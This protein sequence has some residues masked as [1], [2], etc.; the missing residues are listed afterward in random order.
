MKTKIV[1]VGSL[2][3]NLALAAVLVAISLPRAPFYVVAEA[4]EKNQQWDLA[5]SAWFAAM[6]NIEDLSARGELGRRAYYRF[7]IGM[8]YE[9]ED[10]VPLAIAH[11]QDALLTPASEINVCMGANGTQEMQKDLDDLLTRA[12]PRGQTPQV[13]GATSNGLRMAISPVMSGAM[14]SQEAEFYVAFQNVGDKDVVLNLG[15]M[16]ANGKVHFPDSVRLLLTDAQGKTREL[17]FSDKR[18]PGIAGRVDDYTVA[19]RNGAIY[20]LRL[21]L[22]QYWSPSTDEFESRLDPGHYRIAAQFGGTGAKIVNG[23]MEG[24]ELVNFWK[25]L[26]ESNRLEFDVSD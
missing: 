8:T 14:P 13:W 1:L 21:N 10:R 25:G 24:V 26:L 12:S 3:L 9:R 6:H 18:Y 16:L 17:W 7:R 22:D 4:H 15:T 23:D 5:R 19:L 11:V 20:V 2:L